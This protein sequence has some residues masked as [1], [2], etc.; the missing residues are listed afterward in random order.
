MTR[1]AKLLKAQKGKSTHCGLY[2]TPT[3]SVEIDQI[4][5]ISLGGKDTYDNLQLLHPHCHDTK[6][7]QDGCIHKCHDDKP[8]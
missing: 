7:A 5:P 2:F 1:V 4:K 6:T 3:D 8:F